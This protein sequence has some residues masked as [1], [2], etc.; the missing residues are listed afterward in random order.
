MNRSD[1]RQL[2]LNLLLTQWRAEAPWVE[3]AQVE[4]DLV[5]SRVLVDGRRR[6]A[7]LTLPLRDTLNPTSRR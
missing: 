5:L 1:P 2:I 6:C 4:K 3:D 7:G